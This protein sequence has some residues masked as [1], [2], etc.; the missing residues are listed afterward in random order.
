MACS[1]N[2]ADIP[3]MSRRTFSESHPYQGYLTDSGGGK[4]VKCL[5]HSPIPKNKFFKEIKIATWNIK[6]LLDSNR[7]N[8]T[9]LPRRTA[10][11]AKELERY[12]I[13]II[14]LQETHLTGFGQL[15]ERGSGYTYFWSG[16]N[17]SAN[18]YGVAICVRTKLLRNGIISEPT[19]IDDRLMSINIIERDTKTVFISCYAPTNVQ[20][21]N[22]KETFYENPFCVWS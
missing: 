18:K 14:A 16:S 1:Q 4:S 11:I 5:H 17:E 13:D 2:T 8:S 20:D 3:Q 22:V 10:V 12:D 9:T 21:E 15:E 7:K 6:T 19:C